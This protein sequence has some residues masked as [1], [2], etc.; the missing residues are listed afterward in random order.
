MDHPAKGENLPLTQMSRF[1]SSSAVP[2]PTSLEAI[3]SPSPSIASDD[4]IS[5]PRLQ[6]IRNWTS[7]TS[8]TDILV[9][10]MSA[11]TTCEYSYYHY[12]DRE[13]F[14]D[15]V[16]SGRTDFCSSLLVNALLASACFH[17]S[18]V[19]DREKP[20]SETSMTTMFYKEARRLWDSEEGQDSLT[21]LQA[22]ICLFLVLGK[23]GRD[24]VGYTFLVEACKIAGNMNLFA[25]GFHPAGQ[26]ASRVSQN[27]WERV[28]AVTAWALFNFQLEMSFIYS[29]PVM[30]T[31]P[32]S[33][34]VPYCE[35]P[36]STALFQSECAKYV[37]IL[38]C[39]DIILGDTKVDRTAPHIS[40][41]IETCYRRLTHW[42]KSRS[43]DLDPDLMPTRENLLCAMMYHVNIINIFQA[44][45]HSDATT[46]QSRPYYEHARSVTLAS[47]KEIHR[48]LALQQIR[49]GWIDSITL[50]LHPITTASFGT[51]DEIS[52]ADIDPKSASLDSSELYQGL[53]T[54]LRALASLT[55]YSYYAQPLFRL[56]TSKCQTLGIRLPSEV[57]ATLD[58]YM[59]EE[60][61]R[62]AVA[63]VSSQYIP[64][65]HATATDAESARMDAVISGWES[66]SLDGTGKKKEPEHTP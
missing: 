1:G 18:V 50:V 66:L 43:K 8:D 28:R 34:A 37:I 53:R 47:L 38:D 12:L 25:S 39:V 51:L 48:L 21:K 9:S 7:V 35:D 19:K 52:R 42:W 3:L 44:L 31:R 65:T 13:I 23:H 16:A 32:P 58:S 4:S 17:S 45:L 33:V 22:G 60:W 15:D 36:S 10:L 54:C 46:Q 55:S 5:D 61:T 64:D 49:H 26:S 27:S 41:E 40:E 14:L 29:F 63:L 59:T 2:P 57:R 62:N 24:K 30:V 20:F 56:L 6:H 11:W